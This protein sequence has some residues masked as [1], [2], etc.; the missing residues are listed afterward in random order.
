ME[1]LMARGARVKYEEV[2]NVY[3]RGASRISLARKLLDRPLTLTEKMLASHLDAQ[4]IKRLGKPGTPLPLWPD[5]LAMPDSS[6]QMAILQFITAG[7]DQ[8]A[9]PTTVHLDHLIAAKVDGITDLA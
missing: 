1:E 9:L 2:K 6:A 8:T 3:E 7:R 4:E 5:R